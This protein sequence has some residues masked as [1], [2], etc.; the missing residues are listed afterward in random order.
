MKLYVADHRAHGPLI[1]VVGVWDPPLNHY[2]ALF[3]DLACGARE[4]LLGSVVVTL[5]PPPASF[6]PRGTPW[7]THSD[8]KWRQLVQRHCGVDWLV[9]VTLDRTEVD[10][11]ASSFLEELSHALPLKE[12]WIGA[13]QAF[14]RFH[15]GSR[16][17][18]E[19][20][21]ESHGISVRVLEDVFAERLKWSV[22]DLL[23]TGCVAEATRVSGVPPV[24]HRSDSNVLRLPWPP[25]VYTAAPYSSTALN[26][27]TSLPSLGASS[28]QIKLECH[29]GW[30]WMTWPDAAVEWLAF[31]RG[32][33]DEIQG[34]V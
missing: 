34:L 6:S 4:R 31:L 1:G 27:E 22:R 25:G 12:L 2:R 19:A 18:I 28:F 10:G 14:G 5:D 30:G 11:D 21:C 16:S 8:I 20:S 23:E 13:R 17:A 29:D 15:A 3:K 9:A 32:P 7:A 26:A 24:W 33:G